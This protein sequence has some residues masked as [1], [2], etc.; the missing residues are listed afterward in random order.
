MVR[1]AVPAGRRS[2]GHGSRR[3]HA[4]T[5]SHA[6][7]EATSGHGRR[8]DGRRWR[9]RGLDGRLEESRRHGL[10]L[11]GDVVLLG[12]GGQ[13]ALG[14][15]AVSLAL[16]VLLV[17]VLDADV[18]VHEELAVH[19]VDGVVAG[20][21]GAVADEAVALAEP[22]VV[23]GDLGGRDEGAEATEGIVQ[24]LLVDH[25]VQVADEQL[26]ADL[27]GLLLVSRG[28]VDTQGLAV[29]TDAVHDLG[30]VVSVHLAVELDKAEALVQLGDAVLGQVHVD[31]GAGLHHQLPYH[32]IAGALVDVANVDRGFFVL[33]PVEARSRQL[34]IR[35][36]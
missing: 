8:H 21:E 6:R 24:D 1:P 28:L 26:G 11:D 34:L 23:A 19:V 33:L 20:L 17:G 2:E 30:G 22:V 29:Q 4:S 9:R 35:P 27:E 18:L 3:G 13:H 25:G 31:D 36:K 5:S 32:G 15:V 12:L 10:R 16:A 7:V 14:V